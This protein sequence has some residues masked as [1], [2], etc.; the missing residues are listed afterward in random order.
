M[1]GASANVLEDARPGVGGKLFLTL[2]GLVFAG[3][4]SL[5]LWLFARDAISGLQTWTW[6]KTNCAI[7]ASNVSQ[8]E[9]DGRESG[10]FFFDVKYSYIFDGS[11][12]SSEQY[13]RSPESSDNYSKM[14]RLV[15]QYPAGSRSACYVNP[16]APSQAI[17]VRYNLFALLMVLFP[18]PFVAIGGAIIY[19][20]WRPARPAPSISSRAAPA[21]K[22]WIT[23]LFI[24]VFLGGGSAAFCGFF[25]RPALEIMSARSWPAVPCEVI[26]SEVRSCS[27]EGTTY[28]VNI[29]YS[30]EVKGRAFKS[31]TYGFM[32]GSS[33]GYAGKQAVVA[34][35]PPGTK[36]VCY[37]NPAD[38]TEAVLE[39]GFTADMW[40]GLIPL[41]F[42]A[43]GGAVLFSAVR[44]RRRNA[45]AAGAAGRAGV[46]SGSAH[47]VAAAYSS[48]GLPDRLVLKPAESPWVMFVGAIFIC[49]FW[50]GIVSVFVLEAVNRWRSGHPEWGLMLFLIPFV[51]I[52]LIIIGAVVY[53]FMALFNPRPHLTVTPGAVPLGGTLQVQ[54]NLTGR[55][56]ILR[57]LRLRLEGREEA[58]DNS[59]RSS[60]SAKSVFADMEVA[61]ITT[62][63]EMQSGEARVTVPAGLVPSFAAP[64]N[65]ILWTIRVHGRI[66]YWPDLKEEFPVTVLPSAPAAR[67]TL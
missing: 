39:R 32:G 31:N 3:M 33:S 8:H 27:G 36:T 61:S 44:Q 9:R 47:A 18:L 67:H 38:P 41:L 12:Y 37:V 15:E 56:G 60:K 24:L 25:L 34:R 59:R 30:Y 14:A 2:F 62:P 48:G 64:N 57:N 28:S 5:V 21:R 50:N 40:F 55:A 51:A 29:L 7:V 19:G 22:Q 11:G 63:R 42:M 26:S 66:A 16:A 23:V 20:A 49:L 54:W 65:K 6:R 4:G 1:F 43:V 52:G 10:D 53:C 45:L 13:K 17:L 46:L 58:A 35:N